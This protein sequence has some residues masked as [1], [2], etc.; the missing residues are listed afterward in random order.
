M[1]K[2]KNLKNSNIIRDNINSNTKLIIDTTHIDFKALYEEFKTIKA[3]AT[4]LNL[5]PK[6]VAKR[7]Q[8]LGIDYRGRGYSTNTNPYDP[9]NDSSKDLDSKIY[10]AG[11]IAGDG[12][13]DKNKNKIAV[14][15]KD[16]EVINNFNKFINNTG[17]IV[18]HTS[19]DV[20]TISYSNKESKDYLIKK[21]IT[22]KKSKT[23]NIKAKLN[24]SFI[25]GIFDAD[26]SFSQNRFKITTGSVTFKNQLVNF[27]KDNNI[28]TSISKKDSISDTVDIYVLGGKPVLN[29]IFKHMYEDTN[30][31]YFLSRKKEQLRRY[32]Q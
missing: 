2:L 21:G 23:L 31:I 24:W 6:T 4:H 29:I 25:R 15:S 1:K 13:I 7:L 17:G 27:F 11:F 18:K 19:R 32:L 5:H 20:Y 12:Y 28:E 10:W 8:R 30:A 26:G 9:F 16:M 14:I 22:N 3:I